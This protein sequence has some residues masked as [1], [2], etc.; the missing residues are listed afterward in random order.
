[1]AAWKHWQY[2]NP[3]TY[4]AYRKYVID[5]APLFKGR[6]DLDCADITLVLLIEFAADRGL[7]VTFWDNDQVRYPSKGTRQTPSSQRLLSTRS[8]KNKG[9]YIEAVTHRIGAKSLVNENTEKNPRGPQP[10]DLMVK[11]DHA[12]LVIQV[13]PPGITHPRA[14]DK[15]IPVFPGHDQ[16]RLQLNQTEYFRQE[17]PGPE[18]YH[19]NEIDCE[20]HFDYLNHR[21]FGKERAELIYYTR[22][23]EMRSQ[24]FEFRMYK[25]GVLDN[26]LDWDGLGDP[27][28]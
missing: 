15:R 24:G 11:V 21:G 4:Q 27:S 3:G 9:E 14:R 12:A 18:V 23:S 25:S 10:G 7:P 17:I 28:R 1:M 5:R 22:V 26:W 16:A 6:V 2:W 19:P 13:Y 8:W 20:T